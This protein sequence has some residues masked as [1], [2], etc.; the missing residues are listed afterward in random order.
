MLSFPLVLVLASVL[1]GD[2]SPQELIVRFGSADRL[3][4][5][6]AA[7]TLEE[8]HVEALPAL[9]A[10]REAAKEPAVRER[11]AELI[12]RLEARSLERPTMVALDVDDRPLGEAVRVVAASSGFSL[13]LGEA[14]LDARRVTVR[15]SGPLPFWEAVDRLG[16]AGHVRHDPGPRDDA[17]ARDLASPAIYLV[18]GEPPTHTAFHGPLR[19]HLFATHRHRDLNFEADGVSRG[20]QRSTQ[21]TVEVQAFAEPGRFLNPNGPPRLEAIDEGGRPISPQPGEGG[22]Q[23]QRGGTWLTPGRISLLHWHVPLGLP[24]L[25]VRS[26]LKLRGVLP[27][28]IS[29]RRPDPLV[30]P[31]IGAA[32]KTFRQ[33][34]RVVRIEKVSAEGAGTTAI[35]FSLSEDPIPADRTRVSLG[36]ETDYIGDFLANRIEFDDTLGHPLR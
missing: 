8:Q 3:V 6:E 23:P 21:V 13:S 30:I 29:S 10:A 18:H 1:A 20:R 2:L 5:E 32:G 15:A 28:V 19:I 33:G 22:E 26:P 11:F 14:A 25:P 7:R 31:L 27:V 24:E 17:L 35:D 12:A 4:R 34:P 36:V 16:R 9:R